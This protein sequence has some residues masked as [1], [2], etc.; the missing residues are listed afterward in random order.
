MRVNVGEI[1]RDP[2]ARMDVLCRETIPDV[3]YCGTQVF[4]GPVTVSG[5]VRNRAGWV[6]F[7]GRIQA[8]GQVP[9]TRCLAPARV[10]RDI[11]LSLTLSEERAED[12]DD[13]VYVEN[14]VLDLHD[15]V[16]EELILSM[17]MTTLCRPDCKGLC[18]RCGRNLNTGGC[19]CS[20]TEA[21]PRWKGLEALLSEPPEEMK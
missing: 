19:G 20:K 13:Y 17:D 11:P 21:D 10:E 1:L 14:G 3:D 6:T 7:E 12:R 4:E 2:G 16:R 18:P 5:E 8:E 15:I 9:C